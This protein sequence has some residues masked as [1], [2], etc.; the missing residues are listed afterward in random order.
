MKRI[1]FLQKL[2][3]QCGYLYENKGPAFHRQEETGNVI[4][5]TGVTRRMR[6]SY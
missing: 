6:V 4:E 1:C 2:K 3:G 5:K